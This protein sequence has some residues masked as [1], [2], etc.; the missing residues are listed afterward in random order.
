MVT[1]ISILNFYSF[2]FNTF[3]VI[4]LLIFLGYNESRKRR[5]EMLKIVEKA[6]KLQ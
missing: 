1:P 2:Y 5:I 6:E 4:F 3:Y